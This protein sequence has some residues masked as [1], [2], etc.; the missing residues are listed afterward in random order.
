MQHV[1]T[2]P[3]KSLNEMY[4]MVEPWLGD[5]KAAEAMRQGVDAHIADLRAKGA[6]KTTVDPELEAMIAFR[7]KLDGRKGPHQAALDGPVPG[8][9]TVESKA[10][11][12]FAAGR[13][14]TPQQRKALDTAMPADLRSEVPIVENPSLHSHTVQVVY[15]NGRVRMEVG[16]K[17]EPG[18]VSQHVETARQ[19][20]RYRGVVGAV[21]TVVDQVGTILRLTPG[22]GTQGF[23]SRLEVQKLTR[24]ISELERMQA[25]VDERAARLSGDP[26]LATKSTESE[27]IGREITALR[28]QLAEH[29]K[30]VN[31]F[32]P[33]KGKVAALA[34]VQDFPH[35][36]AQLNNIEAHVLAAG[37]PDLA[38]VIDTVAHRQAHQQRIEGFAEWARA[39]G[40]RDQQQVIDGVAELQDA[41]R[42]SDSIASDPTRFVKIGQDVGGRK[43]FD[44]S[45]EVRGAPG[46]P[47]TPEV[48]VE[49]EKARG[50][51][52]GSKSFRGGINHGA[53]KMGPQPQTA[54]PSYRREATVQVRWPPP[55]PVTVGTLELHFQPDGSYKA[56]QPGTSP[57]VVRVEGDLMIDL[58]R[59]VRTNKDY[60][61]QVQ[62]LDAI[63]I[64]DESGAVVFRLENDHRTTKT[65]NWTRV[66]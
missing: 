37:R 55:G 64:V 65:P 48:K 15:D 44:N 63:N 32:D 47:S 46:T 5:P 50:D 29:Q 25:A 39:M 12:L 49:V 54:F 6:G 41:I 20:L 57:P 3:P 2:R 27:A 21:R 56:Y 31:N 58:L 51:V 60:I 61:P 10:E 23:E 24:I 13:E 14:R 53:S 8:M 22:Y 11:E 40:N 36:T 19:L 7:A 52:I 42:L 38:T 35:L 45:I 66:Q 17:A 33:G 16:P 30:Q 43:T 1:T 62:W 4:D 26:S 34:A 59:D 9:A 28:Q 18:H